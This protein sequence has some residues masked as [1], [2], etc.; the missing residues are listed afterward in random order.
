MNH[1]NEKTI[2]YRGLSLAFLF[3]FLIAV[4]CSTE[5]T[6]V[7]QLTTTAEPTEAGSVTPATAETEEGMSIQITAN[8]NEHW[9][10]DRWGGDYSG[11]GN[12][13]SILMNSDK[14]VTA[15]FIKRDY[16]L[17]VT[18]TG[19]G[20]VQEEIVQQKA[21][22]Y[23][24]GTTVQL[25]AVAE[26]GWVFSGWDGDL[27]GDE[28]PVTIEITGEKVVTAVFSG[29]YLAENGVTVICPALEP[30]DIS[31]LDGVEYLVVDNQSL[32]DIKDTHD[33]SRVC[34][35]P[36]TDMSSLFR[37]DANFNQEI[38]SWD[39]SSVTDMEFIFFDAMTFNQPIGG[40][41][42]SK[43]VNMNFMFGNALV[44]N[45]PIGE[46]DVSN[47]TTMRG[48]F[49]SGVND[50][51][52]F[53]QDIGDWDVSNVTDMV[54]MFLNAKAF[55]QDIGG[56]DVSNVT[57]MQTMFTGAS[58]FNQDIGGWD[59]SN[60][61]DMLRMFQRASAFN[62]PIGDWNVSDVTDMISMFQDASSFNQ[63]IS[64]WC[65]SNMPSEPSDFSLNSPLLSEYHPVWGTC[66][67]SET[68]ASQASRIEVIPG[69]VNIDFDEIQIQQFSAVVYDQFDEE[70]VDEVVTWSSSNTN[71]ATVDSEGMAKALSLGEVQIIASSG[72]LNGSAN[73]KMVGVCDAV[74]E[75]EHGGIP[76]TV[77]GN[78]LVC[79]SATGKH[80]M[81]LDLIHEEGSEIVNG[82]MIRPWGHTSEL[83][84]AKWESNVIDILQW[85]E[86][87]GGENRIFFITNINTLGL[88]LLKGRYNN[89][90][91]FSTY[92]VYLVRIENAQ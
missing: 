65:V 46:W 88:N 85:S 61:T 7:Y 30:G 91:I 37:D 68:D 29:L 50:D 11:T 45:Q 23:E 74:E 86:N 62:Q 63:D 8:A 1:L 36:V 12:P 19:E 34:T 28:N 64:H 41:D 69:D 22:D 71:V 83:M 47:V 44:F 33:L 59:V 75:Q 89:R 56:W 15:L 51:S 79:N 24:Y 54:Q 32:R 78:W 2:N 40:W 14:R 21:T 70:M 76:S 81:N 20:S 38:G 42:V 35:T 9:L 82:T 66:P 87:V 72:D 26:E 27:G 5:S 43:V 60:V 73:L 80:E 6:P 92:D 18:I 39:V 58:S 55:N 67:G 13:G 4:S 25:T 17:T 49:R 57:N 77:E 16:P 90:V 10:F 52:A 31:M 84:E 53:N 3:A 48:M